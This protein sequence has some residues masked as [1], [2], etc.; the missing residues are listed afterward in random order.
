MYLVAD[1]DD[2]V[3]EEEDNYDDN[4]EMTTM[5]WVTIAAFYP[6]SSS[7]INVFILRFVYLL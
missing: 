1:D 4:K 2:D 3:D 6:K 5:T 7:T